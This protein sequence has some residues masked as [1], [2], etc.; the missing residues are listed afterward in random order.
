[1]YSHPESTTS[2]ILTY[3]VLLATTVDDNPKHILDSYVWYSREV[4]KPNS[5]IAWCRVVNV[6]DDQPPSR[7]FNLRSL[8]Y[9]HAQSSGCIVVNQINFLMTM[10][11]GFSSV[12]DTCSMCC[13]AKGPHS[14]LSDLA[15]NTCIYKVVHHFE[16]WTKWSSIAEFGHCIPSLYLSKNIQCSGRFCCLRKATRGR[17]LMLMRATRL[18]MARMS[19]CT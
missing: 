10:A 9:S 16:I 8:I 14:A 7:I 4:L 11:V 19:V 15:S 2:S 12:N 5:W 17:W 18:E 1:M 3:V 13:K 6:G